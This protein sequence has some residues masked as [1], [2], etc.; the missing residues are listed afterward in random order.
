MELLISAI[1][2]GVIASLINLAYNIFRNRKEQRDRLDKEKRN[3]KMQILSQIIG[4]RGQMSTNLSH[5]KDLEVAMNQIIIAFQDSPAVIEKF[6]DF[7]DNLHLPTNDEKSHTCRNVR[8]IDSLILL[9]KAM[10]N[11]LG[12]KYTFGND[13][14]FCEPLSIGQEQPPFVINLQNNQSN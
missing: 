11:D 3:Y 6:K 1:F 13:D 7:K 2:S 12:I 8:V 4:Y 5:G 10:C 14:L 9:L